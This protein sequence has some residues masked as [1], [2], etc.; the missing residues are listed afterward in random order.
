MHRP[1]LHCHWLLVLP[2]AANFLFVS[3]CQ[4]DAA[5]LA[6]ALRMRAILVRHF[7]LPRID[8]YLRISIGTDAD[9]DC[10]S[11]HAAL[12]ELLAA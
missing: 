5:E 1:E 11:L 4:H 2:S 3:H 6:V 12:A 10:D 9:C 7:K 8:Q